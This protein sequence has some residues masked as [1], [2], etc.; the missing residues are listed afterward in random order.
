M[1]KILERHPSIRL[2]LRWLERQEDWV[3]P[4]I[5]HLPE[6]QTLLRLVREGGQSPYMSDEI[7]IKAAKVMNSM[8][9]SLVME[10]IDWIDT[11]PQNDIGALFLKKDSGVDE[12][13][14][15]RLKALLTTFFRAELLSLFFNKEH[16]SWV[17][18]YLH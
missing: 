15:Q 8:R 17:K 12:S 1:S 11:H 7:N 6:T 3:D 16:L 10:L 18:S 4:A 13:F 9:A 5:E 2:I 14:R